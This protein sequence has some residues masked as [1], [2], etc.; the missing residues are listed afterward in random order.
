MWVAG[1][2]FN[3]HVSVAAGSRQSNARAF[4]REHAYRA[5]GA[6]SQST[7]DS[8]GRFPRSPILPSDTPTLYVKQLTSG[9]PPLHSP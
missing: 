1:F 4:P 6:T 9:T 7:V 5:P 3:A 2:S 8:T